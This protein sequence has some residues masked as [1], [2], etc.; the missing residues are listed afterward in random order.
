MVIS[1]ELLIIDYLNFYLDDPNT[2]MSKNISDVTHLHGHTLDAL[3][4]RNDSPA[5]HGTP[6]VSNSGIYDSSGNINGEP[7]AIC[8]LLRLTKPPRD[9]EIV[10][11]RKLSNIHS[12]FKSHLNFICFI[13]EDIPAEKLSI[14]YHVVLQATIDVPSPQ[15][16]KEI[17]LRPNTPWCTKRSS[18]G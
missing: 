7:I 11:F 14:R 8:S 1:D 6:L 16:S 10:I 13:N 2:K 9:M 4:T 12:K 18:E 5:L 17:T 15:Q 3:I